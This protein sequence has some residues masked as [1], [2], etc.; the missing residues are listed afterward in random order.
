M[1]IGDVFIVLIRSLRG[2]LFWAIKLITE[3][4]IDIR[5]WCTANNTRYWKRAGHICPQNEYTIN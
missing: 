5:F 2:P 1:D 3:N 4:R